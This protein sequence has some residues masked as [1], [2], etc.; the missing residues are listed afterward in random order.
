MST[1]ALPSPIT[2][3]ER[4][5]FHEHG[6]E[7]YRKVGRATVTMMMDE[8]GEVTIEVTIEGGDSIPTFCHWSPGK[9]ENWDTDIAVFWA[10]IR[11]HQK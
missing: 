9:P 11:A 8:Y 3:D 1:T 7:I 10:V 4:Y 5:M 2:D 6:Y